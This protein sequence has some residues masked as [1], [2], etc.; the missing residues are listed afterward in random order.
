VASSGGRLSQGCELDETRK[1]EAVQ[2]QV[3][4]SP[5]LGCTTGQDS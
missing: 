2:E 3:V 1:D 4:S 5:D